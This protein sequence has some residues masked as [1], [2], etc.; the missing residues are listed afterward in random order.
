MR[1][2]NSEYLNELVGKNIDDEAV[3]KL[4]A[5]AIGPDTLYTQDIVMDRLN[6]IYD[7][8]DIIKSWYYG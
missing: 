8:D 3:L 7:E 1:Q 4:D 6:F 2:N 5:R